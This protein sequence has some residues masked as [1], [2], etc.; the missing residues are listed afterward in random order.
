MNQKSLDSEITGDSVSIPSKLEM[1]DTLTLPFIPKGASHQAFSPDVSPAGSNMLLNKRSRSFQG[2]SPRHDSKDPSPS[3]EGRTEAEER[4]SSSAQEQI[5]SA[6]QEDNSP[7]GDAL[8]DAWCLTC[9][10]WEALGHELSGHWD[11]TGCRAVAA[12]LVTNC[13]R[14]VR[15]LRSLGACISRASEGPGAPS[16]P[17]AGAS[18][19]EASHQDKRCD[20]EPIDNRASLPRRRSGGET[21]KKEL[22]AEEEEEEEESEEEEEDIPPKE[23][24][25][26]HS[27]GHRRPPEPDGKPPRREHREHRDSGV[28]RRRWIVLFFEMAAEG[29][30]QEVSIIDPEPWNAFLASPGQVIEVELSDSSLGFGEETWGSFLVFETYTL[31][32][33][34]LTIVGRFILADVENSDKVIREGF[35][36][37]NIH[38]HLCRDDPCPTVVR[39]PNPIHIRQLR[40]WSYAGFMAAA[41]LPDW[42][43]KRM[44]G[45]LA[46]LVEE[47]MPAGED[48]PKKRPA[49]RT[50]PKETPKG[51]KNE[52]EKEKKPKETRPKRG[53]KP[54]AE[55]RGE[56]APATP[57]DQKKLTVEMW[58]KLK[59][60]LAALR[61]GKD[62]GPSGTAEERSTPEQVDSSE[63]QGSSSV[64]A[65]PLRLNTGAR[66]QPP[67]GELATA[68]LP[69]KRKKRDGGHSHPAAL[70]DTKDVTSKSSK[71]PLLQQA[72]VCAR[73]KQTK[74]KK[75]KK[76]ERGDR[77]KKAIHQLTKALTNIFQPNDETS[78]KNKKKKKR[79]K[80][81]TL[82]DGTI[83]S[84]SSSSSSSSTTKDEE[85]VNS[86]SDF[87]TPFR[88]K[89][90]ESPGSVLTMLTN[91]V[92]EVLEQGATVDL[93]Q[94]Q[95]SVVSGVKILTYFALHLKPNFPT[96]IRELR[97]LHHIAAVL[98]TLRR[99]DL[100]R[101]GDALAA[102]FI[103]L[104]QSMI[105]QNWS[106]AKHMELHPYEDGT[107]A[108][109]SMVLATRKH[110]KLVQKVQG[111][112]LAE[113]APRAKEIGILGPKTGQ[114]TS[115]KKERARKEKAKEKEKAGL[116]SGPRGKTSGKDLKRN[117]KRKRGESERP[118]GASR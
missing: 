22:S 106:T 69:K 93:P 7:L 11:H 72:L 15:A 71:H 52:K 30:I 75:E 116:K 102:R 61:H 62:I 96:F 17:S 37:E 51:S 97:E 42:I 16:L 20:R 39:S 31:E 65:V 46:E 115:Q 91:H 81:K 41:S 59:D 76:N 94:G 63:E 27:G 70:W 10:A 3:K 103:A 85:E 34:T 57:G 78:Q 23:V 13:V 53:A 112:G 55:A 44:D 26:L 104:H 1:P 82:G 28:G 98:D 2:F 67:T 43:A 19:A 114:T 95:Q 86:D 49:R 109:S 77:G 25:P 36:I 89:S 74:S 100:A 29:P 84:W 5:L 90:R 35:D 111:P 40:L 99:G 73:G 64:E 66:L 60:R 117:P 79:R 54:K 47:A 48:E 83:V 108:T 88:K 101:A 12:D 32:D 18:R 107:S 38:L 105:D 92:K 24:K 80:R 87:E 68:V 56:A 4:T 118:S 6:E 50:S 113:A 33:G 58:E 14:Q 9:S 110:A 21:T 8:R 45:W